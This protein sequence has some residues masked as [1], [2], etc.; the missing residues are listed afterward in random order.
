MDDSEEIAEGYSKEIVWDGL[1]LVPFC[2]APHYRSVHPES[3]M[4][5]KAVEYFIE[6]EMPFIALHDGEVYTGDTQ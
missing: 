5:E 6:N 2:I 1:G 4:I 3:G